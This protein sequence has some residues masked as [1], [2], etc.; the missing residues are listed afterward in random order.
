MIMAFGCSTGIVGG[1]VGY[2]PVVMSRPDGGPELEHQRAGI[3]AAF[4]DGWRP[5]DAGGPRVL[6]ERAYAQARKILDRGGWTGL[7]EATVQAVRGGA[8][9]GSALPPLQPRPFI[10]GVTDAEVVLDGSGPG[11]RV[12]FVLP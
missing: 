12:G 10:R 9:P 1:Q 8:Q 11:R 6:T 7:D 4:R 3:E 2:D 5:S